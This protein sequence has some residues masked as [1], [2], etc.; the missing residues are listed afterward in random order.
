MSIQLYRPRHK[1]S[2]E[3]IQKAVLQDFLID[4]ISP[5]LLAKIDL[6][7]IEV[8]SMTFV[9]KELAETRSDLV[10]SLDILGSKGYVYV[11][12]Y[13]DPTGASS[14]GK[15]LHINVLYYNIQLMEKHIY[16]G[17]KAYKGPRS[18]AEA[19][20]SQLESLFKKPLFF[21][22]RTIEKKYL[23]QDDASLARDT[24]AT[25]TRET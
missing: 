22:L 24:A 4:R 1:L 16:S 2:E 3:A 14:L 19:F 21:D 9:E 5:D 17:K 25:E 10:C 15:R 6:N 18:F 7:T 20:G 11:L 13:K 12:F 8:E 23:V